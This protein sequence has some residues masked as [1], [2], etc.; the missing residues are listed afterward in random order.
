M[1]VICLMAMHYALDPSKQLTSTTSVT[2]KTCELEI[3]G[4]GIH[5]TSQVSSIAFT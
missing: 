2:E 3:L 4:E 5:L 1:V